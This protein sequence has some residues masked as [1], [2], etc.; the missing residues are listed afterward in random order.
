MWTN[1]KS[2]KNKGKNPQQKLDSLNVVELKDCSSAK[3][4]NH[5][6][7]IIANS[8]WYLCYA[9]TIADALLA[10]ALVIPDI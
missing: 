3:W 10:L 2:N 1:K 7:Y 8:I 5:F 9:K 4:K 6:G